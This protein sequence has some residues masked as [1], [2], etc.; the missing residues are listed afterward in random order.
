MKTIE[1]T[2]KRIEDTSALWIGFL[3]IPPIIALGI[4][5]LAASLASSHPEY[6]YVRMPN[7]VN[8]TA[9]IAFVIGIIGAIVVSVKKDKKIDKALIESAPLYFVDVGRLKVVKVKAISRVF[10]GCSNLLVQDISDSSNFWHVNTSDEYLFENE[11]DANAFVDEMKLKE[12]NLQFLILGKS[13]PASERYLEFRNKWVCERI[14]H[15]SEFPYRIETINEMES[16]LRY[17]YENFE[18]Y[19][20]KDQLIEFFNN[21]VI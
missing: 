19:P 12:K 5:L 4:V 16:F 17:I 18:K 21:N 20:T 14:A 3:L 11:Q 7:S 8:A 13:I 9:M 10:V 15:S 1:K 6:A 2:I